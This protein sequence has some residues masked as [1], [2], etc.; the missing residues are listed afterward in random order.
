MDLRKIYILWRS[1]L[2][3]GWLMKNEPEALYELGK[4]YIRKGDL[5]V[6]VGSWR[7][8]STYILAYICKLAGA[9]LISIDTFAGPKTIKGWEND[10]EYQPVA[11]PDDFFHTN[12]EKNLKGLP[13]EYLKMTSERALKHIK[14]RSVDFCFLDGDHQLPT[15]ENDVKSYLLKMRKG[16]II[17]GHDYSK[18][19]NPKNDV[20][21]T[22]DKIIGSKNIRLYESIWLYEVANKSK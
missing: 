17:L 16:G 2:I 19:K 11:D 6:E 20:K 22:V 12:I 5:V 8:K 15:I 21:Q 1:S 9:K 10:K 13:V 7:G 3:Q 4:K 14:N 18:V